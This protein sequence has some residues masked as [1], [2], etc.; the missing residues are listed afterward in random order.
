MWEPQIH[1][2]TPEITFTSVSDNEFF[3]S[4]VSTV[5]K[6]PLTSTY[7]MPTNVLGCPLT[8][9][10]A[11]QFIMPL[12]TTVTSTEI[13]IESESTYT[14]QNTH[15]LWITEGIDIAGFPCPNIRN[16]MTNSVMLTVLNITKT[17]TTAYHHTIDTYW[18]TAIPV[19]NTDTIRVRLDPERQNYI[20]A[21][22]VSYYINP[23]S[24]AYITTIPGGSTTL[25]ETLWLPADRAVPTYLDD[26]TVY[27]TTLITYGPDC[28]DIDPPANT[29]VTKVIQAV[30]ITEWTTT[31]KAEQRKRVIFTL[32]FSRH[33]LRPNDHNL[34]HHQLRIHL[35]NLRF[36]LQRGY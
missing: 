3:P 19:R 16:N 32:I 15:S 6:L 30:N 14:L 5:I 24:F 13:P 11:V 35:P 27:R 28:P 4:T 1:T 12:D 10:N 17:A 23:N 31:R 29:T 26:T 33:V 21:Q 34:H 36:L 22:P 20:V 9:Y 7:I 25:V 8:K 2:T 18:S